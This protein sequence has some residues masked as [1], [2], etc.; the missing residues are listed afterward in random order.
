MDYKKAATIII[1]YL[2]NVIIRYEAKQGGCVTPETA[3]DMI[4]DGHMQISTFLMD[5]FFTKLNA[6]PRAL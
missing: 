5:N 4:L 3:K 1:D 6:L 2:A